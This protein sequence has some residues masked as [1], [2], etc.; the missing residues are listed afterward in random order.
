MTETEEHMSQQIGSLYKIS[1]LIG[2]YD[3]PN[4]V[5][6]YVLNE[7]VRVLN[8]SSATISLINAE[9]HSLESEVFYG[10]D[11]D[12]QQYSLELGKGITGW[13]ALMGRPLLANDVSRET[14]YFPLKDSVAH[15]EM[16]VPLKEQDEV[17]GVINVDSDEKNAFT[18]QDLKFLSL[19]AAE[20]GRVVG[21][22]WYVSPA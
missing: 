21:R 3:E 15:S 1:S 22:V 2:Q 20:A 5:L 17:V 18:E 10:L 19:I 8:I 13:V 11:E 9:T 7:I 16:A 12:I 6:Q 4:T 14:R